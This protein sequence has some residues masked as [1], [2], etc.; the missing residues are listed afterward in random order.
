MK[1]IRLVLICAL[2]FFASNA[3]AVHQPVLNGDS[4]L[5]ARTKLNANDSE[6]YNS[7]IP[8]ITV[9]NDG[10]DKG[11]IVTE[12]FSIGQP[13]D[14]GKEAVFGEG[15]SYPVPIA[16]HCSVASTT[17]MVITSA[18]DVS[19]ILQ[20]D[21]DST[22]GLFGGTTTGAY[23]LVGS[24]YT[25]GGVKAKIDTLGTVEPAQVIAE[26][27][28]DTDTWTRSYY[29]V[30]DADYPYTQKGNLLS[31]CSSCSE[32][33][34]F[35][36]DPLNLPVSWEQTTLTI[37]GTPITK[38][39]A[40]F[41]ISGT[42]TT[43]PLIEQL[44]L[45]TNRFEINADGFTQYFGRSRY[46][47][48][49]DIIIEANATKN[50]PNENVQIASGITVIRTDN[51]FAN[52]A[53]DGLIITGLFP[54]GIDT[55]IPILVYVDWY[56]KS[57]GAGDVELELELVVATEDFTYD[58]TATKTATSPV[59]VSL[60]NELYKRQTSV[61]YV[62]AQEALP[63]DTVYG[64]LFRDASAGNVDDTYGSNIVITAV[65][66]VGHFWKP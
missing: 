54:E 17:G 30:T 19:T 8:F 45:H 15:D 42:I 65:N 41:R 59:I 14:D 52:G 56:G 21:T 4:G 66:V 61:F 62:I 47:K 3:I 11:L 50:P 33:W 40:R 35:G 37:N 27:L 39:W 32:Q 46:A 29:M 10:D 43:D 1:I 5:E 64:S 53:T 38:Y 24:D 28:E 12:Q 49:V 16:Y 63:G 2:L 9:T 25:F 6:L 31:S 36:F 23:I 20:S 51:E 44:K 60:D 55:S 57:T 13:G 22:T 26:Y 34:N 48:T 58:G 18:T 7:V